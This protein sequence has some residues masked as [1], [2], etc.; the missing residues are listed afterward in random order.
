VKLL[1]AFAMAC[2]VIS[3]T[4]GASGFPITNGVEVLI[5]D[6]AEDLQSALQRL[7]AS[8]DLRHRLGEKARDMVMANF[9]WDHIGERLLRV[10]ETG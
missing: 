4:V 8:P 7:L 3:T 6:K 2:P 10:V 5:A 1:E 9:D